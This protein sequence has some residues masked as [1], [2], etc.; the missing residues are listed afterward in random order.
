MQNSAFEQEVL[1]LT[2]EFRKKNNLKALVLDNNL[3][4]A[5]R[6][7]SKTMATGDFFAHTG[8]DGSRPW[9]RAE[10]AG[11][12]T[13]FVGENIA[14]GYRTPKAVVDGWIKSPG[15]RANMLNSQYNEIGLGYHFLQNDTGSVNYSSYWTQLFG[16]GTITGSNPKPTPTP[17]PTPKPKPTP[18][19]NNRQVIKGTARAD[20]LIGSARNQKII[21]KSGNDFINGK[22]GSDFLIGNKGRDT[23]LGGAGN[24]RLYGGHDS[25]RLSGGDGN[26]QLMGT[27]NGQ[28]AEK[29]V[30]TGGKGRDTFILGNSKRAFYDDRNAKS[31]G[32]NNYAVITDFKRA[33]GD[34]IQLNDNYSYRLGSTPSGVTKG[35]AL[36]IDNAPGQ[37]DELV[38][39]IKGGGNLQLN[40]S[41]FKFV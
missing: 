13:R 11:Y 4:K 16:K 12:E 15:H 1:K 31:A 20:R 18:T 17:Q 24:D 38:A 6:D 25:D 30:L 29:D 2:N 39:V 7:Y 9:D 32:L 40:S 21:G 37:S 22:G 19:G 23:L 8:K 10:K 36:F 26:D 27:S 5:A 35:R 34:R 28:K 33:E 3:G 41:A 14:A